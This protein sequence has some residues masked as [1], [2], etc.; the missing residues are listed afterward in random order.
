MASLL[1]TAVPCWSQQVV[2]DAAGFSTQVPADFKVTQD[3][4]GSLV[5]SPD[6]S[7][8]V[9]IKSHAYANF[10]AFAND[11][12]LAKDGFTLVGDV[13]TVNA[14]DRSFRAYRS[15][16]EGNL[17]ADTFVCFSPYGGGSL[18]VALSKENKADAAYN[19]AYQMAHSLKFSQPAVGPWEAA[20]KGK[21]LVY[22]YTASGYSERRDLYLLPSG[23][24]AWRSDASSLSM[25]GSGAVAGGSDGI[26]R[27]SPDGQLSLQFRDGHVSNYGLA[28]GRA[29]NEV[30]LNGKRYFVLNQ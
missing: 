22:L 3:A 5:T 23:E 18:V 28:V 1:W 12:N 4:S 20:L 16:P 7:Y 11:A 2:R 10:E 17:I 15:T 24:F 25:N 9:V 14:T 19:Q 8:V 13:R 30:L 27:V 21:H 6:Q 29:G 26:W